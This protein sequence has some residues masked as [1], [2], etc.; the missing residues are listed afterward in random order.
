MKLTNRI[1][2]IV[3]L[4]SS[5]AAYAFDIKGIAAYPVPFN[6]QKK[7]LTIGFPGASSSVH[8]IK[9]VIYDINGDL[10]IEKSGSQVPLYWNGRNSSG[11]HVKPGLYILKVEVDDDDGTYG[12]KIIRILVDY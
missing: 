12:K 8:K 4:I 10:V 2:F 6:P 9:V 5:Q 7:T 11:R 3:I 1:I